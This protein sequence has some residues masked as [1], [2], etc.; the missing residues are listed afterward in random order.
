MQV[1][2]TVD[3]SVK[4]RE[5][6]SPNIV[7]GLPAALLSRVFVG[8]CIN[9]C[10]LPLVDIFE[11]FSLL[12]LVRSTQHPR[13]PD[14]ERHWIASRDRKRGMFAQHSAVHPVALPWGW[15]PS[16]RHRQSGSVAGV[17]GNEQI[18]GVQKPVFVTS[19][20]D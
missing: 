7:E 14:L 3:K 5:L 12:P 15:R 17:E 4:I 6:N 20:R 9:N 1:G 18:S 16:V 11:S 13:G 10:L 8:Q 2:L 19:T